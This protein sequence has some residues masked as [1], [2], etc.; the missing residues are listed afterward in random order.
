MNINVQLQE[1]GPIT[2]MDESE[3]IR[4]EGSIDNEDEFTTWIEYR[5]ASD[6]SGRV[7]HRSV[8]VTLKKPQVL[9]SGVAASFG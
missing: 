4:S 9:A 3:L 6:P 7:V 1:N 2:Q 8:H 5:L